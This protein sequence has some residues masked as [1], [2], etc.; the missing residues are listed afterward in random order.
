[1]SDPVVGSPSQALR[2]GRTSTGEYSLSKRGARHATVEPITHRPVP[3]THTLKPLGVESLG[4]DPRKTKDKISGNQKELANLQDALAQRG[5]AIAKQQCLAVNLVSLLHQVLGCYITKDKQ[6]E[7]L[8]AVEDIFKRSDDSILGLLQS[9]YGKLYSTWRTEERHRMLP[10]LSTLFS[11]AQE[12]PIVCRRGLRNVYGLVKDERPNFQAY[13]L[14]ADGV[15]LSELFTGLVATVHPALA[16]LQYCH[17]VILQEASEEPVSI[18]KARMAFLAG[19]ATEAEKRV[20]REHIHNDQS[21]VKLPAADDNELKTPDPLKKERRKSSGH[22]FTWGDCT[23]VKL[24]ENGNDAADDIFMQDLAGEDAEK[25]GTKKKQYGGRKKRLSVAINDEI[26]PTKVVDDQGVFHFGDF[27]IDTTG[28]NDYYSY[29]G[30]SSSGGSSALDFA[31]GDFAIGVDEETVMK[32][33]PQRMQKNKL[34]LNIPKK[35]AK[36]NGLSI[37]NYTTTYLIGHAA[38]VKCVAIS[39]DERHILSC[40]HE[41][42]IVV[43]SDIHT[44]K[45]MVSFSGHDDTLTSVAFSADQKHVATTSRD[46]NLILWDAITAKVLLQFEHDKVV[47]CCAWSKSG[48]LIVSGCQDKVCR[49]WDTK[50]GKERAAFTEHTAIIISLDFAPDDKNIVSASAD[51]TVRIWS[52]SNG[53]SVRVLKG[54]SGIVLGCRYLPDGKQILS[55]DENEIKLWDVKTGACKLSMHVE[56]VQV[57]LPFFVEWDKHAVFFPSEVLLSQTNPCVQRA[58]PTAHG[59][60]HP[61]GASS[62]CNS[63]R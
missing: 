32:H 17:A 53:Q 59:T 15:G 50:K 21:E 31:F 56:N 44:G 37:V 22:F 39:P 30:G 34:E 49:V 16:K 45:E 18:E 62:S 27:A 54:H 36:A 13:N 33:E 52:A 14:G 48:R 1:M 29:G 51:K 42:V 3:I 2:K 41:D 5:T 19:E 35:Q 12:K 25:T 7:Q 26:E 40:S 46:Q 28:S 11:V 61:S 10:G 38:R 20:L 23:V 57:F 58:V 6:A 24:D 60:K 43:L 55:N 9:H 47:I 63:Q 8:P 4:F